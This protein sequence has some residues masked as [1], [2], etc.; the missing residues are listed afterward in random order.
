M[1]R[2]HCAPDPQIYLEGVGDPAAMVHMY[3]SM[4]N[5]FIDRLGPLMEFFQDDYFLAS[6]AGED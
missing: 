4:E 5:H 6:L 1:C 3:K 2:A